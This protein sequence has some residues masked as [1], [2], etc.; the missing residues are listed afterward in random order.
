[1]TVQPE[2]LEEEEQDDE[3]DLNKMISRYGVI[4][5]RE[6]EEG[7]QTETASKSGV[8]LR[9][10]F[11]PDAELSVSY[12]VSPFTFCKKIKLWRN[13]SLTVRQR[14]RRFSNDCEL[15]APQRAAG[16]RHRRP[17]PNAILAVVML[18]V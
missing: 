11:P 8:T 3:D 1:M 14:A 9:K 4:L 12:I 17:T 16:P 7:E 18:I 6:I 2:N 13:G 15:T 10:V 5:D